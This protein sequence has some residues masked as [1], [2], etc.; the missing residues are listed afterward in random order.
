MIKKEQHYLDMSLL[1][2]SFLTVAAS[3][4]QSEVDD[5]DVVDPFE[6]EQVEDGVAE[7]DEA[8]AAALVCCWHSLRNKCACNNFKTVRVTADEA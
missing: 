7:I 6:D 2:E 5:D 1:T 8:T 4:I 3:S